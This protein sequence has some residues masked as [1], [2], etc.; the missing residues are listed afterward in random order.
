MGF[1]LSADI[2]VTPLRSA[3]TQSLPVKN[4]RWRYEL[5]FCSALTLACWRCAS[6]RS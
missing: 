4:R 2:P 5:L 1:M 3:E 6:G